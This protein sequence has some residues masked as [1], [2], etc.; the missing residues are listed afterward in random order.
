[1]HNINRLLE[2]SVRSDVIGRNIRAHNPGSDRRTPYS[3]NF[4]SPKLGLGGQIMLG[5]EIPLKSLVVPVISCGDKTFSFSPVRNRWTPAWIDTIYR[6]EA[7]PEYFDHA[8]WLAVRE[9]KCFLPDDTF[10]SELCLTNDRNAP[11][12]LTVSL[13]VGD[14]SLRK[15]DGAYRIE[16]TAV[17]RA[18]TERVNING[19]IYAS[20][21]GEPSI[22]VTLGSGETKTVRCSLA[23]SP[24]SAAAAKES[25]DEALSVEDPV[26]VAEKNFNAWFDENVP[27]LSIDDIDIMKLYYYRAYLVKVSTHTPE[28][29]IPGH[30]FNGQIAYESPFG[31][32][33]GAPVGLP[34][35]LQIEEMKWLKNG[36]SVGSEIFNWCVGRGNTRGYIQFTPAAILHAYRIHPESVDLEEAFRASSEH[37][38]YIL[39]NNTR[40]DGIVITESSWRTGAEYQPS[41]YQYT[42]PKWDFR[43]DVEG[44]R[45]DSSLEIAKVCR[46]D[47][48]MMVAESC[49]ACAE[50]A[51]MLGKTDDADY[52]RRAGNNIVEKIKEYF[53]N[54]EKQFFFDCEPNELKQCDEAAEYG[55]FMPLKDD[56]V[57]DG[58]DRV[59]DR[60]H[61]Y[62]WFSAN[63]S[64]PSTARNCPMYFFNNG[65]V[66]PFGQ[67]LKEPH[68]YGCSWNGPVW[69]YADSLVL[70]AL[71]SAALRNRSLRD[72]W[73]RLFGEYSELHFHY[74]DRSLPCIHEHYRSSDAETF[75]IVND[76]FHSEWL[77][78]FFRFFIGIGWDGTTLSCTPFTDEDF[79]LDGIVLGGREY[80]VSQKNGKVEIR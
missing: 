75:S 43:H 16:T 20:V 79:E 71:G 21:N 45:G 51:A 13:F 76:Y 57:G 42:D 55:G 28:D 62:E 4:G 58:Y 23:F 35:P 73:M 10:V 12:T 33:Y 50:M 8:G 60:L 80:S 19:F 65:I 54:E 47:E 74:G 2:N 40:D 9:K 77:E 3:L 72:D 31:G 49:L 52:F 70:S 41:F 5:Y 44:H 11:V 63:H 68:L 69:P 29:I 78:F 66:G 59:F 1:M 30:F 26:T 22:T 25:A 32:W 64:I 17:P 56:L 24:I 61:E 38:R 46:L 53:W 67:T 27:A 37:T 48:N 14:G 39:D 34:V 6:S 7:D 36:D 15:E 18:L